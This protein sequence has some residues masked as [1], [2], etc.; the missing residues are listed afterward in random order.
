MFVKCQ[1]EENQDEL[2][3]QKGKSIPTADRRVRG[4]CSLHRCEVCCCG[5]FLLQAPRPPAIGFSQSNENYLQLE[6]DQPFY[7]VHSITS[8]SWSSPLTTRKGHLGSL[9]KMKIPQPYSQRL[10][11][12]GSMVWPSKMYKP[13]TQGTPLRPFPDHIFR[14]MVH[15]MLLSWSVF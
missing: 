7:Q 4:G 3:N 12:S 6:L 15:K 11:F 10:W 13:I 2:S 1:T 8:S 9:L 14:I 5:Q